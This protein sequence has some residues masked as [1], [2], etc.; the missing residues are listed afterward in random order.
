MTRDFSF[1]KGTLP[2][3]V[4]LR[5]KVEHRLLTIFCISAVNINASLKLRG[6]KEEDR[7]TLQK[8]NY[9]ENRINRNEIK[10]NQTKLQGY[11]L[12]D[13]NS[14]FLLQLEHH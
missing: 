2:K 5:L 11:A 8:E 12:T 13:Q 7:R 1:F 6:T 4:P 9:L 3:Q 14:T 10:F